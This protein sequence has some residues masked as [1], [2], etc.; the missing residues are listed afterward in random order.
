VVARQLRDERALAGAGRAGQQHERPLGVLERLL[1]LGREPIPPPEARRVDVAR[2]R[3]GG[4]RAPTVPAKIAAMDPAS[5]AAA[6]VALLGPLVK[7][8]GDEFAGEAGRAV[9][10]KAESL[11]DRL[12]GAFAG[13]QTVEQFE[14]D[15]DAEGERFAAAL[16]ERLETDEALREQVA[17]L[18]GE[19]KQ[20]GPEVRVVQRMKAAEDVV[21]AE[22]KRVRR[23]RL[24]VEQEADVARGM[25]GVKLDELG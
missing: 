14:R 25:T 9:W 24:S 22:A 10:A 15:P 17:A 12:R 8:V 1:D 20:A 18:L 19:A 21:G 2:D 11:L 6:A 3:G 5:I 16:R 13:E 7:Q 4:G 23:G